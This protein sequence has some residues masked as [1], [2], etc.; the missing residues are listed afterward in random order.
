MSAPAC[1][2]CGRQLP[3]GS[4]RYVS[5]VTLTADFDPLLVVPDDID[6]E[7]ERTLQAMKE[8]AA[9]GLSKSLSEQVIAKRV[10]MLCP[11]CRADFLESLPGQLH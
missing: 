3:T 7:I 4:L 6:G 1:A 9:Q 2:L 5:E 8:A 11:K 10:F